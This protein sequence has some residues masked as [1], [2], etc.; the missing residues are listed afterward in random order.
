MSTLGTMEDRIIDELARSDLQS[1]IRK[2][3]QSAVKHY[4]RQRFYF[5]E[6][7]VTLTTSSSQEYYSSADNADIPNLV[8]IDSVRQTIGSTHEPLNER[9]F[10]YI[11]AVSS[12]S[13]AFGDPTDYAY[14]AQKL[15]FYPVPNQART[16]VVS[17]VKKLATL[18]T[19]TDTNAWMTDAEE[20][21]RMRAKCDVFANVIRDVS[22]E[23]LARCKQYEMDALNELRGETAQRTMTG[24]TRPTQF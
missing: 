3:I 1:Q 22:G 17:G 2:A 21:I 16:I 24:R 15:R 9:D 4:E 19:T 23:E 18:S 10:A 11:D 5:N 13:S 8:E 14:Y 20:L 7:Q 12:S 6:T